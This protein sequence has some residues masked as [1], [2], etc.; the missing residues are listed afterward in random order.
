[1]PNTIFFSWQA[2]TPLGENKYFLKEVLEDVCK[3]ISGDTTIDEALRDLE[4]DTDTKGVA[5]HPPIVETIFKKIDLSSV[6]FADMTFVGKRTD[7]RSTP[8]PN[9]LIEYG[10]ALKGLGKERY[11]LIMNTAYGEPDGENLPFD[12]RHVRW[13]IRYH[14]P[15]GATKDKRA[16]E[17]NKLKPILRDA[18]RA[19]LATIPPSTSTIVLEFPKAVPNDGPARFRA[20]GESLGFK[21]DFVG[22]EPAEVFLKGGPAMWLRVFPS[23][24]QE[25]K[26][27]PHGLKEVA[28]K[29]TGNVLPLGGNGW[30][31][32]RAEDGIGMYA[33]T[34]SGAAPINTLSASMVF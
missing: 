31:F 24:L 34:N 21:D 22:D 3:E 5:G 9:V 26:W 25:K 12:L 1:M 11:V 6:F 33:G 4:V 23:Q 13:P 28:L 16:Q 32:Y 29:D 2:D 19:C 27:T 30:S 8:N 18:I 20:P 7:G 15:E 17:K 14:L 10:W